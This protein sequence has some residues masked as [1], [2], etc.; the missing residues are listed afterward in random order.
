MWIAK[1]NVPSHFLPK[2]CHYSG[3]PRNRPYSCE[4]LLLCVF[5]GRWNVWMVWPSLVRALAL[6]WTSIKLRQSNI[7]FQT[8]A[9][10]IQF[11]T[12]D[13]IGGAWD[14]FRRALKSTSDGHNDENR[15]SRKHIMRM[16]AYRVTWL[17]HRIAA[18]ILSSTTPTA[19]KEARVNASRVAASKR[20][21]LDLQPGSG[22]RG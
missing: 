19:E 22:E 5:L 7:M 13:D 2:V 11:L 1:I 15:W 10:W 3:I 9:K 6:A 17:E 18:M 8:R 21:S 4:S 20:N 14:L 16:Q 12:G